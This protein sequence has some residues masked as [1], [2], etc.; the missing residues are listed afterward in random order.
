[1]NSSESIDMLCMGCM[2]MKKMEGMCAFCGL[3]E[4]SHAVAPHHLPL[5]SILAGKYLVGRVIGE[6]G[7]GITYL[8]WDLNLDL[9]I[10]IKEYYPAGFVTRESSS[11]STITPYTGEKGQFFLKGREKFVEEAKSLAKFFSLPGIVSVKD[12]FL[13]NGTA[14]IVMEYVEGETLRERLARA[15]GKMT[16]E[17]VLEMMKPLIRSLSKIHKAGII[18]RDISPDNIMITE[19]DNVKLLDFGAA[20]DF[21]ESGNRSLSVLLKPGYAPEEQYRSRG[22]Q[23]PWTD[24]YALCA[25]IY[26][27][28]TGVTPDESIER[29]RQDEVRPPSRLGVNLSPRQEYALMKGMA[30]LQKDRY[31]SVE[32]LSEALLAKS[33][34]QAVPA[35]APPYSHTGPEY[36]THPAFSGGKPGAD[37][38]RIHTLKRTVAICAAAAAVVFVIVLGNTQN[39]LVSSINPVQ[40]PNTSEYAAQSVTSASPKINAENL[41]EQSICKFL[42]KP[43]DSLTRLDY[44]EIRSIQ[45]YNNHIYINNTPI[46]RIEDQSGTVHLGDIINCSNLRELRI[47]GKNITGLSQ[48]LHLS[49]LDT[50]TLRGCEI[51]EISFLMYLNNL[52]YLNLSENKITD[53]SALSSLTNLTYLDLGKNSISDIAPLSNLTQLNKLYLDYNN[54]TDLSVLDD[55]PN[56]EYFSAFLNNT[57]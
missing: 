42:N 29:A 28:I 47:I 38:R 14:Y 17:Q 23:G 55:L 33:T 12:F 27:A 41:I 1:M 52:T 13:E 40:T 11:T 8:G 57:D 31:Q 39:K 30:V 51:T 43:A 5:R 19:E 45:I 46:Y 10:A 3:D 50:L 22:V 25:T 7:F 4:R 37:L 56:L 48:I 16:A 34:E 15:G 21:S 26:K 24:V 32:E 54:I 18:H 35:H 6:G 49:L 20:R 53:I 9:K 44:A 2:R 36:P